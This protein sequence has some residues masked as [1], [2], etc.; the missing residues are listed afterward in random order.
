MDVEQWMQLRLKAVVDV[1][2]ARAHH[3][4]AVLGPG[5]IIHGGENIEGLKT[6]GDWNLFDF[7]L[8]VWIN[9]VV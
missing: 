1:P 2:I 6:L 5:L 8:Q 3:A 7:G 4:G 9:L